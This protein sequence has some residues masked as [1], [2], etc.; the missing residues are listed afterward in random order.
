[1]SEKSIKVLLIEDDII[2]QMSFKRLVK[3]KNLAYEYKIA[4]SVKKAKE[5]LEEDRFDVVITD[6]FLGDGTAFDIFE[7]ISDTPFIFT[8]GGGDEKVA[9]EAMKAGAY[10]YHIKDAERNYLEVLPVSIQKALDDRRI[11]QEREKAEAALKESEEKFRAISSAANDAIIMLDYEGNVSF[12]NKAAE[13]IFGYESREM[14]GK[15]LH[16]IIVPKRNDKTHL[17]GLKYFWETGTETPL[18]KTVEMNVLKKNGQIFAIELSLSAVRIEDEMN[19]I[20]IIRDI[21]ER[22]QAEKAIQESEARYRTLQE[23]IPLGI[24]RST[25]D[26]KF[27]SANPSMV[28]ILGYSSQNDLFSATVKDIYFDSEQ[29]KKFG[30]EIESVGYVANYEL[31]LR[32]KNGDIFWAEIN[33]RSI[34]DPK[35]EEIF[36]DGILEDITISKQAKEELRQNKERLDLILQ[37]I[38]NG[39]MVINSQKEI[40]VINNKTREL[41]GADFDKGVGNY[42]SDL[43][44]NCKD[45]GSILKEAMQLPS[46]TNLELEVLYPLPRTLYVTG[47]SFTD[48]DGKSAGRIFI[49]VDVTKE[50]EIERMKTD[51][52][53]SVSH[54]LRTPLTSIIGFSKI[55]LNN[56]EMVTKERQEFVGI[57]Y[58]ES[59]R[60]SNLIEDVLSISKIESGIIT[61]DF[62]DISVAPI[63]KDVYDIYK[64]QAEKKNIK[65]SY[66]IEKKLPLIKADRDAIHQIAVNF[67]GNAIKFT[68]SG[69][70][71]VI[72]VKADNQ[73]LIMEFKDSGM[74][75]PPKDQAKIFEK[76]Y[77]VSRPGQEIQGTGLG[78]SIVKEIVDSHKGRIELESEINKGTLFKVFFPAS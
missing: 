2:D 4:G 26:G 40:F 47:T 76:F 77:R 38:G 15:N 57:I 20:A 31:Q 34:K 1:M 61:Y 70:K 64:I 55:L 6:Y 12:L 74:G 29:R 16:D 58:K 18:G 44:I 69:G 19:T 60:L 25:K 63:I 17:K 56:M 30:D 50:K 7:L 33:A 49:F 37:N 3:E 42:L 46:F 52:V 10:Y 5:I 65:M 43:L 78:L 62:E 32:K 59:Q 41:L 68:P 73:H 54:E 24:Y 48:V 71:V 67:V 22:K 35:T 21:T 75:I 23:N 8:T 36:Y 72:S 39:V 28:K 27:I 45:Q 11:K 51:F 53:S 66:K 14:I 9:V 13:K